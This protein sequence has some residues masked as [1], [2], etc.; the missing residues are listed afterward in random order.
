MSERPCAT[1]DGSDGQ[2]KTQ[3]PLAWVVEH[4]PL[5]RPG[6]HVL[7]V[8]CGSGRH[9]R[10]ALD[11]GFRV[12]GIDRDLAGVGDF[13]DCPGVH[14]STADLETGGVPPFS[15]E[16]FDGVIVTNY[17]WRP[18]LA[19]IVAAVAEDGVLIY[20]TFAAGNERHGRPTR[21][22]FLLQPGELIE[23]VTGKLIVVAYRHG[24]RDEPKPSVMQAIVAVGHTHQGVA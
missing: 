11:A 18:L 24:R 13:A 2:R 3:A 15:A 21:P 4:L 7:D 10:A 8:A 22:E 9:L 17:L 5:I 20:E 12:T 19:D 14:L 6:G 23:A 16:R 1:F